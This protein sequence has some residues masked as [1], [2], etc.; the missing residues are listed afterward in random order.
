MALEV[1]GCDR[2]L[3]K[4]KEQCMSCLSYH[5]I[6]TLDDG[7]TLDGII[8]GIQGDNIIVL[9]GEDI[10]VD[11]SGNSMMRQRPMGFGPGRFRR[12]RRR[13]FPINRINRISP[14]LFPFV[15]PPYL[16]PYYP[17]Y[18]Y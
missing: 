3:S 1:V 9:V 14:I 16:Y 18:P 17:L 10:M 2:D 12:F 11:G 7:S 5:T 6:L 13:G 4:I 15:Y 8:E